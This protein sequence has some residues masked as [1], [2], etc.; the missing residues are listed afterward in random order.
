MLWHAC[1]NTAA[2]C[3]G[4][5][6]GRR[7]S[8]TARG[9]R[10]VLAG[11]GGAQGARGAGWR[12]RRAGRG[13]WVAPAAR[14]ALISDIEVRG[15]SDSGHRGERGCGFWPFAQQWFALWATSE[16]RV[17]IQG[18]E[19]TRVRIL[20]VCADRVRALDVPGRFPPPDGRNPNPDSA[21]ERNPN[22]DLADGQEPNPERAS[23]DAVGIAGAD[24]CH[25]GDMGSVLGKRGQHG[26]GFRAPSE[27]RVRVPAIY[28]AMV[29]LWAT[30]ETRVRIQGAERTRVRILDVCAD[31]V[32]VLDV[33]GRFSPPDGLKP[34][35]DSTDGRNPNP[36]FTDGRN[37]N[38]EC[39]GGLETNPE[40]V[41]SGSRGKSGCGF[42]T[43]GEV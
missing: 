22:P 37:S 20:D 27:S 3:A 38:H 43:S 40:R 19:R 18:A 5:R 33:P 9:M 10:R 29:P 30:N 35:P 36:D 39:A 11:A 2:G 4:E 1:S 12:R 41:G 26:C 21:D 8:G 24:F 13:R 42:W 6:F 28:T 14:K 31:R 15:G 7:A 17:R 23:S 34:N 32:R 25:R 16:T